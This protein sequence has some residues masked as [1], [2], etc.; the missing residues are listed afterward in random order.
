MLPHGRLTAGVQRSWLFPGKHRRVY[1][2]VGSCDRNGPLS[3]NCLPLPLT[4]PQVV[5][6]AYVLIRGSTEVPVRLFQEVM[7]DYRD[8]INDFFAVDKQLASELEYDMK[9]YQEQLA[10]EQELARQADAHRAG[11]ADGAQAV[12]VGEQHGG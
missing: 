4:V 1:W 11:G 5:S 10:Q 9:K 7:Q 3:A 8:E 12:Q 2:L 6:G